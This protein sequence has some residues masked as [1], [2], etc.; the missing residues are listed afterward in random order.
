MRPIRSVFRR[1]RVEH[2]RAG[3][4]PARVDAEVRELADERVGHDLE[5]ERGE[6]LGVVGVA[7]GRA[8]V[9]AL[10][11]A[12][13]PR[14][15]ARRAGWQEVE[16][17]VEQR[18]HALVLERGAAQH[19]R[20]LDVERRLADRR[21][22]AVGGNLGLLED[23][24]D[25]LVVVVLTVSSRCSRGDLRLVGDLGRDVGDVE[26]LAELVLVEDRLHVDQVDDP[27]EVGLGADRQLDRHGVPSR[28]I[29]VWTPCSKFAPMRSILLM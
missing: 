13:G 20:E 6:R 29:I 14:S 12:R 21:D 27:A 23:Q 17:G 25:E 18:L 19:R 4:E 7:G 9:L 8:V 24:L 5:R 11:R 22:Q 10:A 28:S 1:A 3:L 26:V 2:A 15:A 16:H